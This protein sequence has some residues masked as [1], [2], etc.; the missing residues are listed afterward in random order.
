[1]TRSKKLASV[2]FLC[3]AALLSQC[4][5]EA[6]QQSDEEPSP[7]LPITLNVPGEQELVAGELFELAIDANSPNAVPL[8]VIVVNPPEGLQLNEDA[9]GL[10]IISWQ[11]TEDDVG[12]YTLQIMAIEQEPPS[13]SISRTLMLSVLPGEPEPTPTFDLL[14]SAN[15]VDLVE[16]AEDGS[17]VK[18]SIEPQAGFSDT[19][20]LRAEMQ[21]PG[22]SENLELQLSAKELSPDKS[23]ST[24]TVQLGIRA[25]PLLPEE[26]RIIISAESDVHT[27]EAIITIN[28]TPV[29]RD[30]VYL[31]IGQSNMVGITEDNA[32]ASGPG[33]P[34]E[35]NPR[36]LQANVLIN[37]ENL[38]RDPQL[39]AD[40]GNN[41]A[42]PEFTIAEDPLHEP[43]NGQ[44]GSKKR[45]RIG[46]G[47]SFAKTA[48]PFTTQNI[49]LVP[50]AWPS[51]AFCKTDIPAAQ[52]NA[53]DTDN[54]RLGNTL[55][56]DRALARLNRTLRQTDGI[57]RGMLWHQGESDSN[58]RCAA[59]YKENLVKLAENFRMRARVDARGRAART[60]DTNIPFVVG[61]MSKGRDSE[62]DFSVFEN[63]KQVVD[64]VHRS[65]ESLVAH[66]AFV[67]NDDLVPDNGFPCGNTCV[68]FGAAAVREMGSRM[69]SALVDA[70][71]R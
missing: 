46:P 38:I 3:T 35:V 2:I 25:L 69:H 12:V 40:G 15:S 18:I 43:R 67:N 20:V 30:D 58:S 71:Q 19:V 7:I 9:D 60:S 53:T 54:P 39:F 70:A 55:M 36:I 56:F 22:D 5:S 13:R 11:P 32:K 66:S 14:L 28:V 68:H 33:E 31:L 29:Q 27:E 21:T 65:I 49:V 41:F 24:M 44:N 34:D 37:D 26:R 16:G 57:F 17:E 51:S 4:S 61:T 64:N 47:L 59:L 52:W 63:D 1:M 45:R 6:V 50:A 10:H 8:D 42:N 62:S 23:S 48:L